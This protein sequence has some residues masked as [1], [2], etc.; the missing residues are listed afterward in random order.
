MGNFS[1]TSGRKKGK[2][3]FENTNPREGKEKKKRKKREKKVKEAHALNVKARLDTLWVKRG[4]GEWGWGGGGDG[5]SKKRR[6]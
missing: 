3:A 4:R 6:V 2:S 1:V 5:F